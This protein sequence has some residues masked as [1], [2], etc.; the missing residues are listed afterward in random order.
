ME[1]LIGPFLG[2]IA[3]FGIILVRKGFKACRANRKP[4]YRA[5]LFHQVKRLLSNKDYWVLDNDGVTLLPSDLNAYKIRCVYNTYNNTVVTIGQP[6]PTNQLK[7][8]FSTSQQ[9]K[10][11]RLAQ[12]V[13]SALQSQRDQE[14]AKECL[15][16]FRSSW[17]ELR[18]GM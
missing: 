10:I 17:S 4:D 12:G 3:S 9:N 2:M 7:A 13:V 11:N 6:H 14:L 16:K 18:W 8:T 1:H 15:D 5:D